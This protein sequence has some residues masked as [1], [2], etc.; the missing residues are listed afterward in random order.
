VRRSSEANT[1][2]QEAFFGL[3]DEY[4]ESRPHLLANGN[5]GG[6]RGPVS[7]AAPA[8]QP[9]YGS[10]GRTLPPPAPSSSRS[11]PP[12]L[13]PPPS[14]SSGGYGGGEKPDMATRMVMSGLKLGSSGA[15]KGLGMLSNNQQAMDALGR[16]GAQGMIRS[17]QAGLGP[18]KGQANGQGQQDQN[19]MSTSHS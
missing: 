15:R 14:A 2:R 5:G 13:S 17:A 10:G 1:D 18:A 12:M 11:P 19:R 16:A 6:S 7:P 4:F 9:S 8:R 3:L